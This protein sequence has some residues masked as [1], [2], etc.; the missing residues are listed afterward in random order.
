MWSSLQGQIS[1]FLGGINLDILAKKELSDEL[2]KNVT[3][4]EELE[5]YA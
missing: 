2:F 4:E 5:E 1:E 3:S